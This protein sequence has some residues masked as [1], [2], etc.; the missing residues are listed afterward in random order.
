MSQNLTVPLTLEECG[1]EY[2]Y[3]IL[4]STGWHFGETSILENN[5][6][7]PYE[8]LSDEDKELFRSGLWDVITDCEECG[9][10]VELGDL[11]EDNICFRCE[12]NNC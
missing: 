10:Y 5:G 1:E 8:K 9:I 4:G 3:E 2:G 6:H 11:N 12:E 7:P